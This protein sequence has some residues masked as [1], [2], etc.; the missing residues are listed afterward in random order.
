MSNDTDHAARVAEIEARLSEG[1]CA[2]FARADLQYLLARVRE[3][4]AR[5]QTKEKVI[6][7]WMAHHDEQV[8]R[9]EQAES[10]RDAARAELASMNDPQFDG[11][12]V[13]HP[14]Y[15]RGCDRTTDDFCRETIK[16]LDGHDDGTGVNLEPWHSVRQRLLGI[17]AE[18]AALGP[19][20][21]QC[22][23]GYGP[24]HRCDR[25]DCPNKRRAIRVVE[26][27]P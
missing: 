11:T 12:P 8:E 20:E 7:N 19:V 5:V 2:E 10:D 27:K 1:R 17:R 3:L 25:K 4:E 9:A 24:W 14:A 15:R 22:H 6:R 23:I 18:L 16:I 26:V 13:E 21:W